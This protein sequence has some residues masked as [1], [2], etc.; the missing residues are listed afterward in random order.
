[1]IVVDKYIG[2]THIIIR[3]DSV[4]RDPEELARSIK[5]V[6][7]IAYVHNKERLQWLEENDKSPQAP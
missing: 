4:I 7:Q 6:G 1:M 5:R 3:D 2:N